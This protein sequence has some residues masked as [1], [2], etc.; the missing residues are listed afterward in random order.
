METKW[1]NITMRL[2]IG[3]DIDDVVTNF[4]HDFITFYNN[5][6][7]KEI[8]AE[9]IKDWNFTRTLMGL[10]T[11]ER[12][13]AAY[14]HFTQIGGFR[15]ATPIPGAVD[16]L[17]N[18]Q[19]SHNLYFISARMS[20]GISDTYRWF[21][22]NKIG[23]DRMFFDREKGWHAQRI[24]LHVFVDDAIHNL[25][26]ISV[27]NPDTK[28]ILFDNSWNRANHIY[29]RARNWEEI[30]EHINTEVE[31][32]FERLARYGGHGCFDSLRER[33]IL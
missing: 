2:N 15:N 27:A 32:R 19:Q 7:G 23:I 11:G 31:A 16:A 33:E 17:Q 22:E 26:D 30:R 13:N 20:R 29:T 5:S 28:L 8:D 9:N 3:I 6:H 12:V 24:P 1:R 18:L 10:E 21:V 14:N 4:K 25:D